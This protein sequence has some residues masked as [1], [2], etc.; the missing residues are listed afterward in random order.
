MSFFA[1]RSA[2]VCLQLSYATVHSSAV[3][4]TTD[5]GGGCGVTE[6]QPLLSVSCPP[7]CHRDRELPGKTVAA[8]IQVACPLC[9][10]WRNSVCTLRQESWRERE[11]TRWG[12]DEV[13]VD[14]G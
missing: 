6:S 4:D 7:H 9:S 12:E 10:F 13:S 3:C 14:G 2:S 11:G 1:Y 5:T 8:Y